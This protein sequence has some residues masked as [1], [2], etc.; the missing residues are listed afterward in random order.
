MREFIQS[1]SS[2]TIAA[3]LYPLSQLQTAPG[4][5]R[6]T[7]SSAAPVGS[8][9]TVTAAILDELTA[10]CRST[11]QLLDNLQRGFTGMAF[12]MMGPRSTGSD[13]QRGHGEAPGSSVPQSVADL[14]PRRPD[15]PGANR[16]RTVEISG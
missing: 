3:S 7:R 11:F 5:A 13:M 9:N 2:L 15:V 6:K 8:M 12:G 1:L 16:T 10:S 14:H 4:T